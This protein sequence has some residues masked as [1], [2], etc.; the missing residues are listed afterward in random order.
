MQ[1]TQVHH[2]GTANGEDGDYAEF[3]S[4][5]EDGN[6]DA[7]RPRT[8]RTC[9]SW[10]PSRQFTHGVMQTDACRNNLLNSADIL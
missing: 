5:K 10:Q 4:V 3:G 1:Y 2:S 9:A 7:G 6:D 8:K